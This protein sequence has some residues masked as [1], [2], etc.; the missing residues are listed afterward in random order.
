MSLDVTD[1]C[2]FF[3]E[4]FHLLTVFLTDQLRVQLSST[5]QQKYVVVERKLCKIVYQYCQAFSEAEVL[6]L[7]TVKLQYYLYINI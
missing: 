6:I 1:F 4:S 3:C 5:Y 7:I 2:C